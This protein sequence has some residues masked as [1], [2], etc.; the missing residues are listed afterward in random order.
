MAKFLPRRQYSKLHTIID[1]LADIIADT[2]ATPVDTTTTATTTDITVTIKVVLVER[3]LLNRTQALKCPVM[4]N[5]D[6]LWR[7]F[8]LGRCGLGCQCGQP[9]ERK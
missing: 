9:P 3:K 1:M 8:T 5:V 6:I 2:T 7:E 4:P